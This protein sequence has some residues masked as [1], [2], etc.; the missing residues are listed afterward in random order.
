MTDE[1]V[2]WIVIGGGIT[3]AALA[4]ELQKRGLAV[5]LL[6]RHAPLAGA[7]RYSYG[8][9]AYWAGQTPLLQSLGEASRKRYQALSEEFG[10]SIEFREIDLLLTLAPEDDPAAIA[11]RFQ[12]CAVVPELLSCEDAC[13]L[14]PL[15]NRE[16]LAGALRV[17]HGHVRLEALTAALTSAFQ[18]LG[19]R[20]V[21]GEAQGFLWE[22]DRCRGVRTATTELRADQVVV[23]AGGFSRD[24][25]AQAGVQVPLYFSHAEVLETPP[26]EVKLQTMVMPAVTQRFQMEAVAGSLERDRLWQAP[27]QEVTAPVLDVGAIQFLDG[28]L[29]IGQISRA[30]SSASAPVNPA[31]S[32]AA[33]RS[34]IGRV[35]PALKDV[36]AQWHHCLVAFSR[37]G[38][39]LIGEVPQRPGLQ[40]FSGF[41][42]PLAMVLPLAEQF[43]RFVTGDEETVIPQM[44]PGRFWVS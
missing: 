28:S 24:L 13:V 29:R 41:S 11:S 36:P 3:G 39:P 22:G 20:V 37:D 40:V 14:E 9:I 6:E 25:L 18:A 15:L 8:G 33:M 5:L 35:V 34:G 42:N 2:D 21:L 19:G 30:L 27:N 1:A 43:A 26:A 32:E 16:A 4:W 31:A 44:S 17:S 12:S 38:L 23:C 7:S 10:G